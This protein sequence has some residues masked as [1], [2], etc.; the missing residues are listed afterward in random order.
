MYG[1]KICAALDRQHPRDLFDILYLLKN[2]N[3]SRSIFQSFMVYLIS[4]NR[5]AVEL[6]NPNFKDLEQVFKKEFQ[7][8]TIDKVSLENLIQT[9]IEVIDILKK[10]FTN[11]DKQFLISFN[12]GNPKWEL[13]NIQNIKEFPAVKWKLQNI[14]KM[15]K[16][17][18]DEQLIKLSEFLDSLD[19]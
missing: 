7:G 16:K 14:S 18:K 3:I 1:G 15:T 11:I 5:P 4:H 19:D 6:L 9:R 12:S 17:K 8:M 2:G 10:C 13:L